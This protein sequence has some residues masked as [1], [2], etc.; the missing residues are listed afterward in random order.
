VRRFKRKAFYKKRFNTEYI[1]I[2][3]QT[4][5]FDEKHWQNNP[6]RIYFKLVCI[7]YGCGN[8][9]GFHSDYTDLAIRDFAVALNM[10]INS[11]TDIKLAI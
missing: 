11:K 9:E 7:F 5:P 8:E 6:Y 1:H 10:L 4:K 2:L 3:N